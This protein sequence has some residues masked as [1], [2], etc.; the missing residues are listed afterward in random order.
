MENWE[1]GNGEVLFYSYVGSRLVI[2]WNQRDSPTN[3]HYL[4][5]PIAVSLVRAFFCPFEC[6]TIVIHCIFEY[7]KSWTFR[8]D[9]RLLCGRLHK[10]LHSSKPL[11]EF[12]VIHKWKLLFSAVSVVFKTSLLV[13]DRSFY[14]DSIA[15]CWRLCLLNKIQIWMF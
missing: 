12:S 5:K 15:M 1:S 10:A 14:F 11:E 7:D 6:W 2:C 13:E 9:S 4:L 3:V 8:E